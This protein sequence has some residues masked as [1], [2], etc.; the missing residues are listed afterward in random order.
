M[1]SGIVSNKMH[2]LQ[3]LD[4]MRKN[5]TIDIYDRSLILKDKIQPQSI[6]KKYGQHRNQSINNINGI[7][8]RS[9][10]FGGSVAKQIL[11]NNNYNLMK[12]Q[13]S[14]ELFKQ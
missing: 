4:I 11:N 3:P 8:E 5:K 1:P 13:H 7:K 10:S 2:K 12:R 14:K 6:F 9:V